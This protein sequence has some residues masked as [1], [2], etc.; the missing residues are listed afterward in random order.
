MISFILNFANLIWRSTNI[1]K[2]FR[3]SRGL[4]DNCRSVFF[5]FL[6]EPQCEKKMNRM[7]CPAKAQNQPVHPQSVSLCQTLCGLPRVII[8]FRW[9]SDSWSDCMN[10]QPLLGEHVQ[11]YIFLQFGSYFLCDLVRIVALEIPDTFLWK[12]KKIYL[13]NN[14]L[15]HILS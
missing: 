14:Y 4:W 2:Y 11:R 15:V 9:T 7:I 1:L 8:C 10:A 5:I 13:Y 12:K 6:Q 3:E